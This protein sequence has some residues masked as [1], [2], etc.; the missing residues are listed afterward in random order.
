MR[1]TLRIFLQNYYS[2]NLYLVILLQALTAVAGNMSES[3]DRLRVAVRVRPFI[4][5]SKLILIVCMH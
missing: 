2:D 5:F 1:G 3:K 4:S